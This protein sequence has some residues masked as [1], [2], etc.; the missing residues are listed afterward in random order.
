M[1]VGSRC[2]LNPALAPAPI[3]KRLLPS[4]HLTRH[5]LD[6]G[7]SLPFAPPIYGVVGLRRLQHDMAASGRFMA[8][9]T[10]CVIPSRLVPSR[11]AHR[12]VVVRPHTCHLA[13]MW[14]ARRNLRDGYTRLR[15]LDIKMGQV[16]PRPPLRA[17]SVAACDGGLP[18]DVS[19]LGG[20]PGRVRKTQLWPRRVTRD[21]S[22]SIGQGTRV[23]R[24]RHLGSAL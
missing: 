17:C 21:D 3:S 4:T 12:A 24:R 11:F 9:W 13:C 10:C 8:P 23:T 7:F 6:L 20:G 16:L 2:S 14:C 19:S 1:Q 22:L 18:T 5:C 15:M